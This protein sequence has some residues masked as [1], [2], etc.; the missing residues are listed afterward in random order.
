L[1]GGD[2]MQIEL[3]KGKLTIN[4]LKNISLSKSQLDTYPKP[5]INAVYEDV[6]EKEFADQIKEKPIQQI[7]AII[8]REKLLKEIVSFKRYAIEDET[9]QWIR[10][11]G[12]FLGIK[13]LD[14]IKNREKLID[15]LSFTLKNEQIKDLRKQDP[16]D[17]IERLEEIKSN[18]LAEKLS[19][20]LNLKSNRG[21]TENKS[22]L[23]KLY[24][25]MSKDF[26]NIYFF[27]EKKESEYII[28]CT[29]GMSKEKAEE[30]LREISQDYNRA[31]NI[32]DEL[33]LLPL[34][35]EI[36]EFCGEYRVA[37][38][39]RKVK[40]F[41]IEVDIKQKTNKIL[42]TNYVQKFLEKL[43]SGLKKGT[44]F[45][46]DF[47][48]ENLG[49]IKDGDKEEIVLFDCGENLGD[50]Q[51]DML[52]TAIE[53]GEK[54]GFL[55]ANPEITNELKEYIKLKKQMSYN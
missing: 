16:K 9:I 41:G 22:E 42:F 11:C 2:S 14:L 27:K 24:A 51:Q 4:P 52:Q 50:F 39:Q 25:P 38:I 34:K 33:V 55:I 8:K 15:E 53:K 23:V 32:L 54:E 19:S 5:L 29:D 36:I 49:M 35:T 46:A 18:E 20:S 13:Y 43:I 30:L 10:K 3:E 44:L 37:Q 48:Y 40:R 6:I 47:H 17:A 1:T 45:K 21:K 31:H 26:K 7:L 12:P 28:K